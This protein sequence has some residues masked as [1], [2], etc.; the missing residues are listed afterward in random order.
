MEVNTNRPPAPDAELD[1]DHELPAGDGQDSVVETGASGPAGGEVVAEE[2]TRLRKE[3]DQLNDRFLRSLADADNARKRAQREAAEQRTYA[4]VEAVRAFLPVIDGFDRAL[5][6]PNA[7]ADDLRK[8]IEMLQKQMHDALRRLGV[9]PLD[10]KGKHF[11]P[12]WHEAIETVDDDS[13][14]DQT[15]FEELQRGYKLK[16]RLVRPSMVR[17]ARNPGR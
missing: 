15:V 14:P 17:V 2:I 12:H 6:A 9:E 4:A 11:D 1:V 16:E 3:L 7:S 5:Q 10:A 13:S 8:G